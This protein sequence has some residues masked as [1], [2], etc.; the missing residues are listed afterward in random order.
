VTFCDF[1]KTLG[2][3]IQ[4]KVSGTNIGRFR[5]RR[6]QTALKTFSPGLKRFVSETTKGFLTSFVTVGISGETLCDKPGFCSESAR[7]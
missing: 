2:R 7:V 5:Y 1:L 6:L 3:D 4:K